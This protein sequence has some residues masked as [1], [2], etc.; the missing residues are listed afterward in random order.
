MGWNMSLIQLQM[1]ICI[2]VQIDEYINPST[3]KWSVYEIMVIPE[4][5]INTYFSIC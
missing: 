2:A 1:R 5:K 4:S 3:Y